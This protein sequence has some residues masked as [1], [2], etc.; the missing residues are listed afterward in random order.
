M[1]R[2]FLTIS[3]RELGERRQRGEPDRRAVENPDV[4]YFYK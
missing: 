4:S 2:E 1:E 3:L